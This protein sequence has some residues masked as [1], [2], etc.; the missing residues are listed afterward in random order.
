MIYLLLRKNRKRM[1]FC[2]LHFFVICIAHTH[3]KTKNQKHFF[4]ST[5]RAKTELPTFYATHIRT[6]ATQKSQILI[7]NIEVHARTVHNK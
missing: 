5:Q 7:F 2:V 1:S 4:N 3:E 6:F